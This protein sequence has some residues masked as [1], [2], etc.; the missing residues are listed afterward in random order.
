MNKIKNTKDDK[1]KKNE[2]N[3]I[4]LLKEKYSRKMKINKNE[5]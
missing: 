3:N 2:E 5:K 1:V 4:K